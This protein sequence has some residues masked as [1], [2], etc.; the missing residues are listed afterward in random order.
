MKII[1]N[2][3]KHFFNPTTDDSDDEKKIEVSEQNKKTKSDNQDITE[4]N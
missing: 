1:N 4:N 2:L 3:N